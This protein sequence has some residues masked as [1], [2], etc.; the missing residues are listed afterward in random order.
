MADI[1][2]PAPARAESIEGDRLHQILQDL[3]DHALTLFPGRVVTGTAVPEHDRDT[4]ACHRLLLRVARGW[5]IEPADFAERMFELYGYAADTLTQEE[6]EAIL[7]IIEPHY[8]G[9]GSHRE[10]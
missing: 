10:S 5:E 7:L 8:Q 2:A 1:L 9:A 6:F 4:P 3:V